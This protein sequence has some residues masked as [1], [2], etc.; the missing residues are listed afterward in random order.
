MF[1]SML[2]CA[3]LGTLAV[4]GLLEGC[5]WATA[6]P[7]VNIRIATQNPIFSVDMLF[8]NADFRIDFFLT[9]SAGDFKY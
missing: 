6:I 4:A 2:A 9:L 5:F 1:A 8:R 7:Q 3:E